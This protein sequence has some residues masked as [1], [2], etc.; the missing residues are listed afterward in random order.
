MPRRS[1]RARPQLSDDELNWLIDRLEEWE[2]AY[3]RDNDRESAEFCR[4][5]RSALYAAIGVRANHLS[6]STRLHAGVSFLESLLRG[7]EQK[8]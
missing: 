8:S 3:A 4:G 1:K 2:P 6:R 5:A 7:R